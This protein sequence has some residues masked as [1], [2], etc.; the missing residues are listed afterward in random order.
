MTESARADKA[1]G[2]GKREVVKLAQQRCDM[3]DALSSLFFMNTGKVSV[4]DHLPLPALVLY[5]YLEFDDDAHR[6]KQLTDL[7]Y[8]YCGA[9]AGLQK[10]EEIIRQDK[11]SADCLAGALKAV[12]RGEIETYEKDY[13]FEAFEQDKQKTPEFYTVSFLVWAERTGLQIPKYIRDE[14]ELQIKYHFQTQH[15]RNEE[16]PNFPPIDQKTFAQRI[17]EPLWRMTDALLYV[18]GCQSNMK[19]DRK[20]AFLRY[21]PRTKRLMGYILDARR[22]GDLKLHDFNDHLFDCEPKAAEEER[23]KSFY[24]SRVKPKEF[25]AWLRTL[26]LDLPTI[27]QYFSPE[28]PSQSSVR[29][30]ITTTVAKLTRFVRTWRR[31]LSWCMT[32]LASII[33]TLVCGWLIKALAL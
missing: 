19:E 12:E 1:S 7:F 23:I 27:D 13:D 17:T 6:A 26:S 2:D 32:I 21:K 4:P 11:N 24:A 8:S 9:A 15:S 18:L 3:T 14:L 10:L 30:F 28:E 22:T 16:R 25:V 29:A 20:I 5:L 33:A 31:P